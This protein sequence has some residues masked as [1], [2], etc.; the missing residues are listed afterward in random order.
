VF[1]NAGL[2]GGIRAGRWTDVAADHPQLAS[3][4]AAG[5]VT[6]VDQTGQGPPETIVPA[7]CGRSARG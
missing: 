1:A 2:S 6:D 3:W 7:C 4:R 5:L